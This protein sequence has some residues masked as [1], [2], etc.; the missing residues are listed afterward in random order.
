MCKAIYSLNASTNVALVLSF[1]AHIRIIIEKGD[2]RGAEFIFAHKGLFL[3]V[4][5]CLYFQ[6]A[7]R[8]YALDEYLGISICEDLCSKKVF[9]CFKQL[10][11]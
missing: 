3:F 4:A 9:E 7:R 10:S 1:I 11:V 2:T 5:T 8:K 6:A